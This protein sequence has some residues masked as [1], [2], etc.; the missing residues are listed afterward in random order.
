M[1]Q[2]TRKP[3]VNKSYVGYCHNC[4]HKGFI[5]TKVLKEKGCVSKGCSYFE[6][7]E[8]HP[9]WT[10][11]KIKKVRKKLIKW[12]KD[13]YI[14]LH[15]SCDSFLHLCK[16]FYKSY[17]KVPFDD[18]GFLCIEDFISYLKEKGHYSN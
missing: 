2:I 11:L 1:K 8:T 6:K 13:N 10:E 17:T 7:Y 14:S 9:Y 4:S 3:S 15:I 5:T 12:Y 16:K 18:N